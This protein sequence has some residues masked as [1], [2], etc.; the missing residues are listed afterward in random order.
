[1]E[2]SPSGK[3]IITLPS[4]L[5]AL[6]S[7]AVSMPFATPQA[8]VKPQA[9]SI[10]LMYEVVTS[11]YVVQSLVPTMVMQGFEKALS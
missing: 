2:I 10:P 9:A 4:A 5:I 11:P 1:M 7:A 8:I 6:S 3:T